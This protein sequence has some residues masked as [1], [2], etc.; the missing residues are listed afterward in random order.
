MQQS[1]F[2]ARLLGP[3][4]VVISVGMLANQAVYHAM[5]AEFLRSDGLIYLSGLASL[6]AGL[7]IVNVHNS[8]GTDWRLIITVLGWLMVIGGIVRI[9]LPRLAVS[10]GTTMYE[11]QVTIIVVA[12]ITLLLGAFLSYKG[13]SQ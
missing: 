13:Y 8:W 3:L 4:F 10:I 7:A 11:P 6:L 1:T 12:V 5:I 2:L 9:V